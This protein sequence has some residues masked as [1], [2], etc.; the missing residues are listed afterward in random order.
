MIRRTNASQRTSDR[1]ILK[2]FK[3]GAYIESDEEMAV[4][5]KWALAGLVKFGVDLK[6]IKPDAKLTKKGRWLLPVI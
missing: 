3:N 4:L 5:K 1:E 2:K 6:K